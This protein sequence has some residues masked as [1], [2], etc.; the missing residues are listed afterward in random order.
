MPQK[1]PQLLR[2]AAQSA[3]ALPRVAPW[4]RISAGSSL[5]TRGEARSFWY[6]LFPKKLSVEHWPTHQWLQLV[7]HIKH[8]FSQNILVGI[9]CDDDQRSISFRS[10]PT[11][12]N[13][14][15]SQRKHRTGGF[16]QKTFQDFKGLLKCNWFLIPSPYDWDHLRGYLILGGRD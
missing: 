4:Q 11:G 2:L 13:S 3:P 8:F 5:E 14:P 15:A 9:C 10:A 12:G 16:H 6:E 1:H 7:R